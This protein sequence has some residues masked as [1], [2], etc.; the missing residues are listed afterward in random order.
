MSKYRIRVEP[1]FYGS[2]DITNW[3]SVQKKVLGFYWYTVRGFYS[4]ERAREYIANSIEL[5]K[6]KVKI[7]EVIEEK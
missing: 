6:R 2:G 1:E 7:L 4:E 5:K 3:Y